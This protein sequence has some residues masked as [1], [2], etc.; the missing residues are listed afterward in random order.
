MDIGFLS[1]FLRVQ[2]FG[3]G[4]KLFSVDY[5]S[6]NRALKIMSLKIIHKITVETTL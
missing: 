6:L 4:T 2:V 1:V 5:R 3:E